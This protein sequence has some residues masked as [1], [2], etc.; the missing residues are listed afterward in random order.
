MASTRAVAAA[1]AMLSADRG[2]E[3][4]PLKVEAWGMALIN[5]SDDE[6]K[7]AVTRFMVLDKGEFIPPV[8]KIYALCR[9]PAV[10]DVDALLKRISALGHY[11]P[12]SGWI[13]P[14]VDDVRKAMGDGIA[15]AYAAAGTARCFA[16]TAS[17]GSHIGRDIARRSFA[18]ELDAIQR[19]NPAALAAPTVPKLLVA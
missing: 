13:Y 3:V 15:E 9:P 10:V 2:G 8:S 11:N 12:N 1:L 6:L 17:D 5:I 4:G 16:D 18:A 7:D 19:T 14:R